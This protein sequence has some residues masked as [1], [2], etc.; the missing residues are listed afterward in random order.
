LRVLFLATLGA[1]L[2]L[3]KAALLG[4][5]LTF[6]LVRFRSSLV[7]IV[8]PVAALVALP[9]CSLKTMAVKTVANT[10][11]EAGDVFSRDNDP[12]LVRDAIPFALKL[13]ESLLESVPSHAPL[14]VATC[15]GFTQYGY[16]FVETEADVLGEAHHDESKA[17]RE[18]ALKLYLRGRDYCLR[19][20]D[21]R[22]K[23]IR[24]RLLSDPVAALAKTKASD[25]PM[26]YWTAASWG[27]AISLGID[28]PDLVV[29]FPVVR[30]IAERALALDEAWS[31][32]ALHELMVSLDSLPEALG[33]NPARAREHFVRAVALQQGH[34][35]GPYVALATG[36]AVPAQNKAE[37]ESLLKQALAVDPSSDPSNRLA[38]LITQRR[39]RALLE[40]VDARF[41]N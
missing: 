4:A 21:V 19:S 25:V 37:F 17:L 6:L 39:A 2:I 26:L 27:A 32:G 31:K 5:S 28:Q 34:S 14:L 11:A 1:S 36:V 24:E 15:S 16:A 3:R 30:A 40:Q 12:E 35:P 18:R 33:G 22:F 9:S 13:Y 41:A 8:L 20:M 38:T 29:D 10:L 23:G 7:Q